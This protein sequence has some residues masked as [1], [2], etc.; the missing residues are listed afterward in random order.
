MSKGDR[1]IVPREW[2][3]ERCFIICGGPSVKSQRALIPQLQGRVIAVKQSALLRPDADV[4]FVSGKDDPI[5]CAPVFPKFTGTYL[6]ARS[7]YVNMPERTKTLQ[8][9]KQAT[10][11]SEDP[12]YLAGLDGGTSAINLAFLFGATEIVL[13]GYDMTG[14]RWF[15]G[16]IKHHL[17]YPPQSHFDRHLAGVAD[18]A[19]DLRRLGVRV[20]NVS[21]ISK[22]ACFERGRLEEFLS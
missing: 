3:G 2:P 11:L 1:W 13:L 19:T 15:N 21:P 6:V 12:R 18:I 7:T 5:V 4:M 10:R 16:E 9:T 22:V 20:V 17:P 8:R 14:G